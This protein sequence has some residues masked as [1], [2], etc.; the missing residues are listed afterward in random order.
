MKLAPLKISLFVIITFS[1]LIIFSSYLGYKNALNLLGVWNQSNKMSI[2]L[3]VDSTENEKSEL[4]AELKSISSVVEVALIDRKQAA[5]SFQNSLKEFATGLITE[6]EMLDLVPESIELDV[7]RK[8]TL[9]DREKAFSEIEL[10]IKAYS[11]VEEINYSATWL[12]KFESI[13]RILRTT[14]FFIFLILLATI[15][16]LIALML[17]AYIEE[18]KQEVEVYSLLG[19]TRWSIY[20]YFLKDVSYFVFLSLLLAYIFLYLLFLVVKNVIVSSGL[21]SVFT[22][23]LTF[24]NFNEMLVV[25]FFILLFIYVNA[26]LT[27][28]SSV[29]R[30]NQLSYD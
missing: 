22:E 10:K 25:V 1:I 2:Y 21:S 17:K 13:D 14:G 20:R 3:K 18:S 5:L 7:D 23:N 28:Q 24:L 16:Y 9:T 12:K 26:Y 6:D 27:I 4:I 30:L 15:S 29:N 19:A 11:Q 8:L